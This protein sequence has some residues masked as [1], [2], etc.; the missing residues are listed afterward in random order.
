LP[1]QRYG[2]TIYIDSKSVTITALAT[3]SEPSLAAQVFG[4]GHQRPM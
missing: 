1:N 2:M 3:D 4:E